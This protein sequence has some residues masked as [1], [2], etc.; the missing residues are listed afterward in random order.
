VLKLK[1]H[2]LG[3]TLSRLARVIPG[4]VLQL[5]I[6][7]GSIPA[8]A[9]ATGPMCALACCAGRAPHA[10]GSCMNGSCH[11][12][13]M[14]HRKATH[15]HR[16]LPAPQSEQLCGLKRST[17]RAFVWSRPVTTTVTSGSGING[18]YSGGS[19]TSRNS[20]DRASVTTPALGKRCQPDCGAATFSS[21]NQRR[22]RETATLLFAKRDR[23]PSSLRLLAVANTQAHAREALRWRANPRAP[24]ALLLYFS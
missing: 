8:A 13:L 4:A 21:T 20:L 3:S 12:A 10:A 6:L 19:Q 15:T 14:A 22:P 9:V 18:V 23:P 17:A 16:E 5:A 24:P 1:R 7:W 11:A 2:R